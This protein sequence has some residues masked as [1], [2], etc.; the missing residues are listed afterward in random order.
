M[1][2]AIVPGDKI[3]IKSI[4]SPMEQQ[5]IAKALEEK[6]QQGFPILK[7]RSIL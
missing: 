6:K 3:V 5:Q 4:L 7:F 1:S 2:K